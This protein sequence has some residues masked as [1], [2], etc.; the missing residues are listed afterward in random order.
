MHTAG[1]VGSQSKGGQNGSRGF[2]M[3]GTESNPVGAG[4]V[5]GNDLTRAAWGI[6][7][8]PTD[9]VWKQ[10]SFDTND[11]KNQSTHSFDQSTKRKTEPITEWSKRL[12][13]EKHYSRLS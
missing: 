5:R 2:G 12:W 8:D 10:Y 9:L 4:E 1:Q 3:M 13:T 7:P 11:D 6:Q